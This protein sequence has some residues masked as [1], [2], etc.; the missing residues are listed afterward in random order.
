MEVGRHDVGES[1]YESEEKTK[2]VVA[3][4]D[5]REDPSGKV[6]GIADSNASLGGSFIAERI[7][8]QYPNAGGNTDG[9]EVDDTSE[10]EGLSHALATRTPG[11][12]IR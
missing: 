10:R 3:Y 8:I 7:V 1:G 5:A 11:P 12:K 4:G 9:D 2:E 6:D